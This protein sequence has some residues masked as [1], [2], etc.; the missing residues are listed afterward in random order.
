MSNS[1][2]ISVVTPSYQQASFLEQT[3]RSVLDQGYPNLEYIVMDGGS[4]D[5]SVEIIERYADRLSFW[6][7]ES[8][9][10]QSDAINK[11]FAHATGDIYCWINSD[12]YLEPNSLER[13]AKYFVE[14]PECEVLHGVC[15]CVD[16]SGRDQSAEPLRMMKGTVPEALAT[17]TQN[18]FAQ[19]STFWRADLW[20][21]VGGLDCSLHYAMD[22]DLWQKFA[23][24]T[25][26]HVISDVLASYR[27]HQAA[28][29]SADW[30]KL[31]A[32]IVD[33]QARHSASGMRSTLF[34][35]RSLIDQFNQREQQLN[36]QLDSALNHRAQA[37]IVERIKSRVIRV[38]RSLGLVRG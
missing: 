19:Q 22:Y 28:K 37:A 26:F 33:V 31:I 32:E 9:D 12:D 7:S 18:W 3:I 16:E 29:C 23:A 21:D 15:R 8:D 6:V 30:G 14:H 11:G 24:R 2:R 20:K 38:A 1:P 35:F 5:G 25:T 17:W 36:A 27:F 13:V 34:H 10:G 4:T